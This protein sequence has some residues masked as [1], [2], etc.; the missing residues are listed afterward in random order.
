MEIGP[1]PTITDD[2]QRLHE[3]MLLTVLKDPDSARFRHYQPERIYWGPASIRVN[4]L[5]VPE[6]PFGGPRGW[7]TADKIFSHSDDGEPTAAA[8]MVGWLAPV[9]INAKNSFGGYTGFKPHGFIY[10][11][12]Q[13]VAS[14][15]NGYVTML[16]RLP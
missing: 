9:H 5:E 3:S 6:P 2:L 13:L 15:D 12:G 16:G 14:Y 8:F 10:I 11:N 7:R 4:F 1:P